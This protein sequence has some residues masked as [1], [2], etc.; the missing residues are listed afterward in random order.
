MPIKKHPK[1]SISGGEQ[2]DLG[3]MKVDQT[4]E[5][6]KFDKGK[7]KHTSGN[8][9]IPN[10]EISEIINYKRSDNNP[11]SI[12]RHPWEPAGVITSIPSIDHN[13]NKNNQDKGGTLNLELDNFINQNNIK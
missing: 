3:S 13:K 5:N 11:E 2:R 8:G 12:N 1:G 10:L 7:R 6:T 4:N 9:G